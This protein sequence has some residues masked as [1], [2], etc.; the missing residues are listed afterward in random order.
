MLDH[1]RLFVNYRKTIIPL[2]ELK[3][4]DVLQSRA[5]YLFQDGA[6]EKQVIALCRFGITSM[7]QH[8]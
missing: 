1:K 8:L 6:L 7:A 3:G 5:T 2:K 4:W